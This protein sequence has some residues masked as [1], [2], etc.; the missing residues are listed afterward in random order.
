MASHTPASGRFKRIGFAAL[1]Y[2]AAVALGLGSAWW[3]LR[4]ASWSGTVVKVGPWTGSTLAGSTD[5]DLYTRAR[6]ALEGLLAL[7]RDETMYYV[8]RQDDAGQPL[9]SA[10]SYRVE[11]LPP[12]ARWWSIT[13]YADDLFL[14]D[15]RNRQYSLN[16]STARLDARG[17]FA[18]VTGPQAV[19]GTHWLPTPGQRGLVLTLRLYNPAP[20]LQAA[21]ARLQAP[22]IQAI[23]ACP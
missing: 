8:A 13:A 7:G 14:F 9:R 23:G 1:L 4:K 18:L 10:C 2:L 20:E 15:A 17:Q 11:G 22:T 12:A 16:G 3:V 21:P 6:V 5:A 19:G